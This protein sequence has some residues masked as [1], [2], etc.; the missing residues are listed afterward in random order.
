MRTTP[1]VIE[2]LPADDPAAY[3]KAIRNL[4][5]PEFWVLDQHSR[6]PHRLSPRDRRWDGKIQDLA[7]DIKTKLR[8]MRHKDVLEQATTSKI[9]QRP[10]AAAP[11]RTVLLGQVTDD[12]DEER[13]QVRRYLEQY[14]ILVLPDATYPQGGEPFAR[15]FE[16][17]L[18]RA[19]FFVQLLGPLR[20][21]HPPDLPQGYSQYQYDAAKR[22][23]AK[24]GH[25][26]PL[27]WR[28]PDLNPAAV[29]H[30]EAALLSAPETLAMG[31]EAFKADVVR[32]IEQA[33]VHQKPEPNRES[34]GDIRVFINADREDLQL[35]K[36]LQ[37][38]FERNGYTAFLPLYDGP[39]RDIM[40][41]LEEKIVWCDALALLYGAA[42]PRWVS[43]QAMLYSKLRRKQRARVVL[44]CRAPPMPKLDHGVSMPELREI[45][46]DFAGVVDPIKDIL[47]ELRQ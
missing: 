41:D 47:S 19:A 46:Y 17:D 27:L 45:D 30:D 37:K 3:P 4:P 34:E 38:N 14:G 1:A 31:L 28:R 43:R 44:L 33:N 18:A 9:E 26:L 20:S 40:Q 39:S 2:S 11:S 25:L 15:A 16:A 36:A 23:A 21:R 32:R 6:R 13:N 12:L 22:E 29:T 42:D 7:T 5:R 8:A 24:G 10:D 35:A